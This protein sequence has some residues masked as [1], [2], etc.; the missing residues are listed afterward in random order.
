MSR[1]ADVREAPQQFP[2]YQV[3]PGDLLS[4]RVFGLPQFD[5]T[6]RISNSGKIHVPYAGILSVANMTVAKIA[7]EIAR[8][9]RE[10]M[11]VKEPWVRVQVDEYNAQP[12]F[13]IGEVNLPGQFMITG[14]MRLL[15]AISKAG[16]LK[17]KAAEEAIL[18]RHRNHSRPAIEVLR[19]EPGKRSE[20]SPQLLADASTAATEQSTE[21]A[22]TSERT[23]INVNQL[24]EGSRPELNIRLQG[25][26]VFYV[27][28]RPDQLIYIIGEVPQPGAYVLPRSYDHI[29][30]ARAVSYAGGPRRTAKSKAFLVRYDKDGVRKPIPLDL[31]AIIK[32][33]QPD[34]PVL[35]D[36][37]IFVPRSVAKLTGYKFIDMVAHGTQQW[38]IF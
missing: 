33:E 11:L 9:L 4:I 24:Q 5:Q 30:A 17:E 27:P 25:G 37:I 23:N 36:D 3:G 12:V 31:T 38:L 22:G 18:I 34:I 2:E 14:E 10:R 7:D 15:D 20:N 21:T 8:E 28:T 13:V 32:G 29:T 35:P 16:G 1:Q 19:Q 6:T 26:D